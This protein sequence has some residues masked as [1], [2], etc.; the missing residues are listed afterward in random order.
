MK[1]QII[2]ATDNKHLL[3][4]PELHPQPARNFIPSWYKNVPSK[5]Y[6]ETHSYKP[7][8]INLAK[9]VKTCPS[10]I[11]V[12]NE[13]F[14]M[15]APCD[16][17][18]RVE[19][20]GVWEWKTPSDKYHLQEH[21]DFQ[22]VDYT[23]NNQIKKI[24][25][26]INPW[27]II[28]PKGYSVRQLPMMYHYNPNWYV[29]YGLIKTDVHHE[30]HQQICI[31]GKENEI[32]IKRGDPLNYIVPYK[33]EK[34]SMKIEDGTTTKIFDKLEKSKLYVSSSFNSNYHK[35]KD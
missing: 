16:I 1:K 20:N 29:S 33:R 17:W 21:E 24:L 5:D 26:L 28:T 18:I 25:K 34:L 4:F 11:E 9:T 31:T 12:F 23:P 19:D 8:K 3:N 15:V 30:A 27:S 14:V 10:F 32:L 22:M 2:F 35:Y 7:K 6:E 13:G